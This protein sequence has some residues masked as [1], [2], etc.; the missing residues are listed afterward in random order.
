RIVND[1]P[2]LNIEHTICRSENGRLVVYI[3][4][5]DESSDSDIGYDGDTNGPEAFSRAYDSNRVDP[6]GHLADELALRRQVRMLNRECRRLALQNSS[7]SVSRVASSGNLARLNAGAN[8]ANALVRPKPDDL[9]EKSLNGA[10]LEAKMS[11]KAKEEAIAQL[12]LEI[13]RKQTKMLLRKK[14]QEARRLNLSARPSAL[15]KIA[16]APSS[17]LSAQAGANAEKEALS[18]SAS[19]AP[20]PT[21][22]LIT[23][24]SLVSSSG[25]QLA[26]SPEVPD[27]A[28]RLETATPTK[29]IDSLASKGHELHELSSA[30]TPLPLLAKSSGLPRC[31]FIEGSI[32]SLAVDKRADCASRYVDILQEAINAKQSELD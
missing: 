24:D 5:S 26:D 10:L 31:D 3:N 27:V 19:T 30:S 16:S 18:A 28:N 21:R 8:A 6:S 11:L 7:G 9:S 29:Q 14:L 22:E 1:S 12:R 17:P 23:G 25:D 15:S 13:S 20:T 4:S 2:V 32:S